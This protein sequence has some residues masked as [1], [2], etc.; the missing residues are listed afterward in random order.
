MNFKNKN[1]QTKFAKSLG[2]RVEQAARDVGI[3]HRPMLIELRTFAEA[4]AKKGRSK[5]EITR[6]LHRIIDS[7]VTPEQREMV[8]VLSKLN[9]AYQRPR[10]AS[11]REVQQLINEVRQEEVE[12]KLNEYVP[13]T[14]VARTQVILDAKMRPVDNTPREDVVHDE[15]YRLPTYDT[16][17]GTGEPA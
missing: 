10:G 11:A 15:T 3:T 7:Y 12:R 16:D 17:D 8:D 2:D 9:A 1:I 6:G 5:D 14:E 4:A 13:S